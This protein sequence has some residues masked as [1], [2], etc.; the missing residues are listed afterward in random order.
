MTMADLTIAFCDDDQ[1]IRNHIVQ[2]VTALFRQEGITLATLDF[3]TSQE[4]L[5]AMGHVSFDVLFL[6]IDMPGMDGVEFG[7]QFRQIGGRADIVF[8]SNMAERVYDV[9]SVHPW[10]FVRKDHFDQEIPQ[11]IAAYAASLRTRVSQVVL[12][13]ADGK[14]H[15]IQPDTVVYIESAGKLQNLICQ[16]SDTPFAVRSSL[17]ELEE[18]F[19]PLGFIRIH[20]GFLVNYRFVQKITSRGVVLDTGTVLP[21]G[22]DRLQA[23]RER[24]LL[25][26]KWKATPTLS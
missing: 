25:L 22:R 5:T 9:F 1:A 21:V 16:G 19:A 14:T 8:V 6:D 23:V 24:Y 7:R 20:K 4:L 26:M 10:G 3:S 18:T 2:T 11:V 17:M 12:H 15:I 13:D